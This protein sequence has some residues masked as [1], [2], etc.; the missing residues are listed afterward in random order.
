MPLKQN[1]EIR[2]KIEPPAGLEPA[3]LRLKAVCSNQLSYGGASHLPQVMNF[4]L[5]PCGWRETTSKN[6]IHAT[7]FE[8]ANREG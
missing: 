1:A 8:P 7:G 3:T 5:K 2:K 6:N 4:N